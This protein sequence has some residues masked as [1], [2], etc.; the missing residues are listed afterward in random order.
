MGLYQSELTKQIYL[1]NK[2]KKEWEMMKKK[3]A[4]AED[5]SREKKTGEEERMQRDKHEEDLEELQ[6]TRA[7]K[8]LVSDM[9]KSALE[10]NADSLQR[11]VEVLQNQNGELPHVHT[12]CVS[13]TRPQL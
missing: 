5:R 1:R 12:G 2:Q 10:K 7:S 4:V 9:V 11:A 6:E 13:K 8:K 3:M